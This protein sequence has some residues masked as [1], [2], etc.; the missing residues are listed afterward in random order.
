MGMVGYMVMPNS[1]RVYT[2]VMTGKE[3]GKL[4][5][6]SI[7]SSMVIF[8]ALKVIFLLYFFKTSSILSKS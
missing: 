2:K 6:I 7:N 4:F 8:S 3:I 1:C 5:E